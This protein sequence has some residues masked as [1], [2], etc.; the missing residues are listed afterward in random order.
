MRNAV[1]CLAAVVLA[2]DAAAIATNRQGELLT[3]Q[4]PVMDAAPPA[5]SQEIITGVCT[6]GDCPVAT[7]SQ[8][9][10]TTSQQETEPP[11]APE[12]V[13][14]APEEPE[15]PVWEDYA[16]VKADADVCYSADWFCENGEAYWGGWRWTW[17]S[18]RVLPGNGLR[19]QGRHTSGGYVR[20]EDGYI[21]LASDV[22]EY[23]TVID[24]PFGDPG[25]V[26]DDGV[27]RNDTVDVYVGW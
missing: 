6:F 11:A 14:L 2:L 12:P 10:T 4:L 16:A 25:R 27:G 20:D 26:Y 3:A 5:V 22:L 7:T 9:L 17:Y 24:T 21:C 1:Y 23:G 19:I 18:E 8:N 13:P 15:E